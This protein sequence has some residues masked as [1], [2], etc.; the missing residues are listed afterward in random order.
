MPEQT[1]ENIKGA[2]DRQKLRGIY[3][4]PDSTRIYPN[5][6]LLCHVVGFT[7][8][9]GHGMQGVEKSM[10]HYLEGHAGYRYITR[11]RAGAELVQHRGLEQAANDGDNV[12]LTIDMGL[13]SIVEQEL[14]AAMKKYTPE[15][16][17]RHP[18]AP[19][20]RRNPGDGQPARISTSTSAP[21]PSRSR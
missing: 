21:P 19:E 8:F 20:D 14:D 6:S 10:N 7:D 4:E 15:T 9:D 2:L 11:D 5:G 1:A 13:Q 12:Q 18:H 17:T 3:F 16:A